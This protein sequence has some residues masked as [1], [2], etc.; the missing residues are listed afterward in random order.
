MGLG[1]HPKI[2][3]S[4]HFELFYWS[5][6]LYILFLV[7]LILHCPQAWCWL[8]GPLFLFGMGKINMVKRWLDGSGKTYVLRGTLLPSQV[9]QLSIQRPAQL[10][11]RAGDWIFINVPAI[12]TFEWHPFTISSAPEQKE[13]LTLHIRS[14]GGWTKRLHTYFKE[15]TKLIESERRALATIISCAWKISGHDESNPYLENGRPTVLFAGGPDE[16]KKNMLFLPRRRP[17]TSHASLRP[18]LKVFIDGPYGAPSSAVFRDVDHA[19]LV[20]T[21]IGVTPFASILQSIMYRYWQARRKCPNCE[22]SWSE[23]LHLTSDFS[24]RKVDFI[25]I[26][27]E[28]Q[29][30]EWFLQLLAQLEMEQAEFFKNHQGIKQNFLDIHLHITSFSATKNPQAVA[31]KLALDLMHKRVTFIFFSTSN[32][33]HSCLLF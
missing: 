12:S 32:T 6:I 15:E 16:E 19:I 30:F 10:H 3:Q 14:V 7:I 28:Q 1:A 2:R 23:G 11:F 17:P 22:H 33:I 24:L 9:T 29:S 25:W 31:L 21:G 4:G 8:I 26:N 20:A 27:K 5:H 13:F 18:P